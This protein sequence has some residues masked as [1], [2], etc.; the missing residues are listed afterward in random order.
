[1]KINGIIAE[2]NPF[3][4]GHRYQL[5]EARRQTGADYT[6]IAMSGNFMQR[7]APALL[8]KYKRAEMALLNGADLVLELPACYAVSSAEYFAT[9]A[10]SLLDKLGVT[11][12]LC[13]GSECGDTVILQKLA[14]ILL[15][16]PAEYKQHLR[17][18]LRQGTS[19]PT[20]RTMALLEYDSDLSDDKDVLSS[21]NNILGIEYLKALRRRSSE[22]IPITT[23]RVGSDYHDQRLNENQ[24][25]ALAIRQ[26]VYARTDYDFLQSQMPAA[27]YEIMSVCLNRSK[28][29]QSNDFSSMLL[30]KLLTE[31]DL[32]YDKYMD[33]SPELSDRISNNLYQFTSFRGFCDLIKSKDMTYTRISRCLLHILLNLDKSSMDKYKEMDYVPYARVL[34]FRKDAAPLLNSIKEH[35]SIPL[36]TKLSDADKLLAPDALQMLKQDIYTSQIYQC[37]F[38][39]KTRQPMQ[40]EYRTPLVIIS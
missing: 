3:H 31:A 24:C 23:L 16:E 39:Q 12:Y 22:I 25:S 36:I 8:D 13:F 21:P 4:N 20:A 26:A 17:R 38:S 19:Y 9:G 14:D 18:Y 34:G 30:Y 32:G 11:N 40:N 33:I 28:P 6:I 2:Y 37:A 1:M 15:N 29:V 5:E 7:G 10:V 27:A 35:S